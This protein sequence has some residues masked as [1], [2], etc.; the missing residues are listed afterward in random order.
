MTGVI[1][2]QKGGTVPFRGMSSTSSSKDDRLEFTLPS[3]VSRYT[4][5]SPPLCRGGYGVL[6]IG[7]DTV[8]GERVAIKFEHKAQQTSQLRTEI[9]FYKR[10]QK[11]G[12][13]GFPEL[14]ASGEDGEWRYMVMTLLGPSLDDLRRRS[15][16]GVAPFSF[17]LKTVLMLADQALIRL[18]T[19]HRAGIC[20]RDL[21]PQNMMMGPAGGAM[22]P[23]LY[24]IDL[25]MGKAYMDA[26]GRHIAEERNN[27]VLGT[28]EYMPIQTQRSMRGARREDLESLAYVM[29]CLAR[30]GL[31]WKALN[32]DA[33]KTLHLKETMPTAQLCKGLPPVFATWLDTAR[34][35]EFTKTPPYAHIRKL[36]HD[37]AER[38]G[39][40]FDAMYD[41]SPRP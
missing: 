35:I 24:F 33:A 12:N 41:W 26:A 32:K 3:A 13:L 25:G 23:M 37:T 40:V 28:M 1:E 4:V 14:F 38:E 30:G 8:T 27:V 34:R 17:S 7:T 20:H 10:L 6:S 19:L 5:H 16:P 2:L 31:P 15:Y 22:A 21:K 39:I 9:A 11:R 18:E 29:I 36:L